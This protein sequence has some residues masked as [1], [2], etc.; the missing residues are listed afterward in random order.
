MGL[1]Q[2]RS[3]SKVDGVTDEHGPS[4]CE[5]VGIRERIKQYGSIYY[6]RRGIHNT[7]HSC[8]FTWAQFTLPLSTGGIALVLS[9]TPH[10]FKGLATIGTIFFLF[11]LVTFIA[12]VTTIIL[13]F[14]LNSGTLKK[15]LTHPTE[16]LFTP[17]ILLSCR[18]THLVFVLSRSAR[19]A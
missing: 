9:A 10:R 17:T 1:F 3:N 6:F 12:C 13:R 18:W 16:F 7:D 2:R 15:S 5:T 11:A 19:M 14:T 8:S 4:H